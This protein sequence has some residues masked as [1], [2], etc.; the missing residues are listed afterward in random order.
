MTHNLRVRADK[1]TSSGQIERVALAVWVVKVLPLLPF[2]S[3]FLFVL[4]SSATPPNILKIYVSYPSFPLPFFLII[5][6]RV[7][8]IFDLRTMIYISN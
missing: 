7:F 8:G 1:A 3:I 4:E 5:S 2:T 6:L